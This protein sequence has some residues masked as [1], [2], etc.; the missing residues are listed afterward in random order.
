MRVLQ[1]APNAPAPEP[2]TVL[3]TSCT[4]TA[5]P[6]PPG[7]SSTGDLMPRSPLRLLT[8]AEEA[9]LGSIIQQHRKL[10][11]LQREHP[12]VAA[13]AFGEAPDA[14]WQRPAPPAS[15]SSSSSSKARPGDKRRKWPPPLSPADIAEATALQPAWRDLLP[16]LAGQATQ[17][18]V[19]FNAR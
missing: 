14:R 1:T 2:L 13:A 10:A 18:L 9:V 4:N 17:L 8:A 11:Q 15:P 12:D 19:A 6:R 5:L 16:Q 3:L 7:N